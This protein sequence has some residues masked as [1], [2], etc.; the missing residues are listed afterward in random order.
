[1]WDAPLGTRVLTTWRMGRMAGRSRL[2]TAILVTQHVYY[3]RKAGRDAAL[4][5]RERAL[6]AFRRL[7]ERER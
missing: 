4:K 6:S 2:V 7:Y 3:H 5:Q 1:M